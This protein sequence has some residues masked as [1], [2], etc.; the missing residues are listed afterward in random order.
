MTGF[1][2]ACFAVLCVFALRILSA[3]RKGPQS[4]QSE[5]YGNAYLPNTNITKLLG[6][7]PGRGFG[8]SGVGAAAGPY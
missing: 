4:T 3:R 5:K 1:L 8:R 7:T 2:F 6:T